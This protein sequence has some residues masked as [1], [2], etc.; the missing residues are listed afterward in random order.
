[1]R[2]NFLCVGK[3]L[4]VLLLVC[5]LFLLVLPQAQAQT[6]F[7]LYSWG[8][9]AQLGRPVGDGLGN[10][11][12]PNDLPGRV[13]Q[14]YWI[15]SATSLGGSLAVRSDG[16]LFALEDD[17]M[18]QLGSESSWV[19]ISARASTRIA[20]NRDG[21]IFRFIAGSSPA[22]QIPGSEGQRWVYVMAGNNQ[23]YAINEDG[24]L[25][26]RGY[27]NNP[28]AA[29]ISSLG[30]G[31][32]T[33]A[34]Y[35]T[36]A[37]VTVPP[38]DSSC[39]L[40]W[41]SISVGAMFVVAVTECGKLWSWGQTGS[42]RLGRPHEGTDPFGN[43]ATA[44]NVPGR[45]GRSTT[46]VGFNENWV[47][48][49]SVNDAAAAINQQ[50]YLYTWGYTGHGRLGRPSGG[51]NVAAGTPGRVFVQ[52]ANGS[53]VNFVSIHGG[54]Q[55]FLAFT[56]AFELYGWGWNSSGQLGLGNNNV[57]P[58]APALVIQTYGF[59]DAARGGGST[60]LMLMR[61][62]PAAGEF[63][64]TKALQKPYG[65]PRP[66]PLTFEFNM[67]AHSFNN[68]TD[69]AIIN[70]NFPTTPI[71]SRDITRTITINAASESELIVDAAGNIVELTSSTDILED[72]EFTRRG[73]YSWIISEEPVT[74]P[75]VNLPSNV[76]FSQAQY[77][78]RVYVRQQSGADI[79][80]IYAITVHRIQD[81]CGDP[82]VPPVKIGM[83]DEAE[84]TFTN[85]YTRL[86]SAN[87]H[88]NV[89]KYI[90]GLFANTDETF[91]FTAT[92]N[93][94]P[95]CTLGPITARVFNQNNVEVATHSFTAA[96][97]T[98][99]NITL[100]HNWRLVFDPV[101]IG[102]S[103]VVIEAPCPVHIARVRVY[104]HAHPTVPQ[105]LTNNEPDQART[106]NTHIIGAN[107]NAANFI[108]AHQHVQPVG[109]VLGDG[110]APFII[111][112]AGVM[113][114]ALLATKSRK[115][116]EEIESIEPLGD[117]RQGVD[118]NP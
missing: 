109:L 98:V 25:W 100:S 53:V 19:Q 92:L 118:S 108:N 4:S 38:N 61:T 102:S 49:G 87:Q 107:T 113:F 37:R 26:S 115:R 2:I 91:S 6:G 93:R 40:E 57:S 45:V 76:V 39:D 20:L 75:A 60:S 22:A 15:S 83:N 23:V 90:E 97:P 86:T 73:V 27:G 72:I 58:P 47:A 34:E 33:A 42:D 31:S 94:H 35:T 116:I 104:S 78:F 52:R 44:N 18:T 54:N 111:I 69:P 71:D 28:S 11:P 88:L 66:G 82:L 29:D 95:L 17:G 9:I 43:A 7:P 99:A 21:Q 65:T 101:T 62:V 81:W 64:L 16:R 8:T 79:F 24:E 80:Y 89:H 41:K 96:N 68:D 84:I 46:C 48:V 51:A 103:F 13:G 63:D 67:V 74:D 30:R 85:R 10:N 5:A 3:I 32:L 114:A 50:G 36:F 106:T 1:M 14:Y 117:E 12:P 110:A 112:G 56:T 55:H 70:A 59:S 77:E 105:L